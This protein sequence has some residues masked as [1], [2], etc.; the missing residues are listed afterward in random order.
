[1][2]YSLLT[3]EMF[4]EDFLENV[5]AAD[6]V[7]YESEYQGVLENMVARYRKNRR[8]FVCVMDGD[9]LAGYI[10]FFPMTEALYQDIVFDSQQIRDDDI[11][12]EEVDIYRND[13]PNRL[14]IISV[15]ILPQYRKT[16]EAIV[17]LTDGFIDYLN[18]LQEEGYAVESIYG[19]AV[20]EDGLKALR[21]LLFVQ[22]RTLEDGNI[23]L[24]CKEHYLEKL[25]RK[26][27]YFKSFKDDIYILLPFADNVRNTRVNDILE[28]GEAEPKD[29]VAQT[30][31]DSLDESLNYECNNSVVSELRLA[32]LGKVKFLHTTDDYLEEGSEVVVGLEDAYLFLTAHHKSHMYI[33]TV[34]IPDCKYSTSQV[35]DQVSY[36]YLKILDETGEKKFVTIQ[37]YL[38][39]RYGLLPCGEGKCLLCMSGKP[40]TEQEFRNIISG[41]AYNSMHVTYKVDNPKLREQ[42]TNNVAK[43]DYYE[44]YLSE[45]TI[46]FIMKEYSDEGED[47]IEVTSTYLFIAIL[48]LFQNTAIAKTN[49]KVSNALSHEGDVP[50]EY[51]STLYKDFG[52]T[53]KFWENHNFKYKGAQD[54]AMQ[55]REAFTNAELKATYYEQ[56]EFL[57]HIVDLKTMQSENRN[58]LVINI[59]AIALAVLQVQGFIVDQLEKFYEWLGV[60]VT[61]AAQTF[62]T[63]VFGGGLTI[64]LIYLILRRRNKRMRQKKLKA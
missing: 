32:Y 63:G 5:M 19:T 23:L 37:E 56:Q 26:E 1:M 18:R 21:N 52:K 11:T 36:S 64:L 55:I 16:K 38:K 42:C 2:N 53:V 24:E 61:Y 40:A 41:E 45:R 13:A 12:P 62:N 31:L 9:H 25:L 51:I 30:V 43:Y 49:M 33:V 27:L 29:E 58:G 28:T 46:A 59:V 17:A 47:R 35:E 57:E 22:K 14:F 15:V 7:V 6:R 34:L 10:N 44:A 48:V 54:E 4:E 39:K 50:Y 8:T 60:D 3:G 20:S